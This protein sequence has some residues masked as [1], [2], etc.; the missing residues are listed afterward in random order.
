M[1]PIQ[2]LIL[3]GLLGLVPAC[4]V[5]RAEPKKEKAPAPRAAATPL[6]RQA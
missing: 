5:S 4:S 2:P 1:K 3:V 6:S